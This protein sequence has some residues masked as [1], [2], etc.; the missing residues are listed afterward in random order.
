MHVI[1][2]AQLLTDRD[3]T[4]LVTVKRRVAP[5]SLKLRRENSFDRIVGRV[6]TASETDVVAIAWYNAGDVSF[7]IVCGAV[8]DHGLAKSAAALGGL[9]FRGP[10]DQA[11]FVIAGDPVSRVRGRKDYQ[12]CKSDQFHTRLI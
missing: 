5:L 7:S 12:C 11:A 8:V 2:P 3:A 1:G 6:K 10:W 4:T 9:N